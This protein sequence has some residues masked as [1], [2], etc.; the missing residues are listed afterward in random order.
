M[1][2][3]ALLGQ[4]VIMIHARIHG[5]VMALALIA[6]AVPAL[7]QIDLSGSW[8]ARNQEDVMGR[9]QGPYSVDYTGLPL[10]EWGLARA[11]S[12]SQSQLSM[13]ERECAFYPP[14]YLV[15]GPFSL[16]IW[17]ETEPLNGK[18]I[19]WHIGGWEDKAP[20]TIWMDGRPHP[21][22]YAPHERGG[23]T[24][25]VWEGE[26]LTTYTTH[27]K[28]GYIRRNGAPTSDQATMTNH[29]LRH[30]DLLTVTGWI[31]DP[32]YLTEPFYLT[33]TFQLDLAAPLDSMGP[34]CV[35]GDEGIKEGEVPHYLPGKNP[36]VDEL[37]KDYH[38][39]AEA[40]MGG[41]ETM[42]PEY[43]KKLKDKYVAPEK[44]V[45]NCGGPVGGG[46]GGGPPPGRN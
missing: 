29:F 31:E 44:C 24:T 19:A 42:Y 21:S 1:G 28:A 20:Q 27:M 40:V 17:N 18:T 39:P 37:T 46:R 35:Q 36:F 33:R 3:Y 12:Y 2:S 15:L 26:V 45:R 7:A 34:P 11:L 6:A 23:F 32:I 5:T 41:A 14:T 9:M 13:P 4:M 16:K 25:G 22:K 30:D 8:V 43:R 38:I 10:N